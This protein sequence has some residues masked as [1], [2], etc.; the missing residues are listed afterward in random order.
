[1]TGFKNLFNDDNAI[2][3]AL[4]VS[5]PWRVCNSLHFIRKLGGQSHDEVTAWSLLWFCVI[6]CLAGRVP[7]YCFLISHDHL[8]NDLYLLI[9][10]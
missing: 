10:R 8:P 1:M 9:I 7:D 3:R 5:T 2:N 4:D 6:I